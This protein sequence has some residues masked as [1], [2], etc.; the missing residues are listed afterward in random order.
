MDLIRDLVTD[1]KQVMP[2]VPVWLGGPE[3]SFDPVQELSLIH[4]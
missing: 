1:L 3:V 4:I 2:E